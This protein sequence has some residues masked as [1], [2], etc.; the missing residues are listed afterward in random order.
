M[1]YVNKK[2][3]LG[4]F[5][6]DVHV[7]KLTNF[8][9]KSDRNFIIST[10]KDDK[11]R[12]DFDIGISYCYPYIIN[13]DLDKRIWYNYHPAPLPQY[14]SICCYVDAIND[15]VNKFGVTL[16]RITSKIDDGYIIAK[17]QFD[18]DSIPI[19]VNEL[20]CISHYYLFQLFKETINKLNFKEGEK[21]NEEK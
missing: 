11:Y 8:L 13:M 4:V 19:D 3:I 9:N 7:S 14:P 10:R 12:N 16:H 17:K 20:G 18:L 21:S 6:K 5:T 15:R 2:Y 1:D